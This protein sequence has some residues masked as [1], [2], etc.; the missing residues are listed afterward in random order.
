MKEGDAVMQF[1]CS[2]KQ[3]NGEKWEFVDISTIAGKPLE[4]IFHAFDGKE[5]VA[6]FELN[7]D[8][9]YFCG[10]PYWQERMTRKGK[11]VSFLQAVEILRKTS[12]KL[13]RE[14]IPG[15]KVVAD[16][17][18]EPG[19]PPESFSTVDPAGNKRGAK[20]NE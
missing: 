9:F 13:L 16:V 2:M 14:E 12:P 17:F 20:R 8:R 6:E 11:A 4:A 5:I 3:R 1:K 15:L 7:N 18:R 10:T 19:A